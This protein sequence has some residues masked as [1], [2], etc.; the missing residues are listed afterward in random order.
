MAAYEAPTETTDHGVIHVE[1]PCCGAPMRLA[2][3]EWVHSGYPRKSDSDQTSWTLKCDGCGRWLSVIF[4]LRSRRENRYGCGWNTY[5][6]PVGAPIWV[7]G[8]TR[9][10]VS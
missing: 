8:V 9:E 3:V 2:H 1:T 4:V 10:V 6:K 7:D 5:A